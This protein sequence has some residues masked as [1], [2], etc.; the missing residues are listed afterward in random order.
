MWIP[1]TEADILARLEAGDLEETATFDAKEEVS[2]SSKEL[3]K[4]VV[5]MSVEGGVLLYGVGEDDD[6]RV[7]VPAPFVLTGVAERITQ[8][9]GTCTHEPVPVEVKVIRCEEDA[10][11]GYVAVVVSPSPR[12]P[13]MVI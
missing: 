4:D 1:A 13:H 9:I 3:A 6:G 7:T 2:S 8:I 11:Q 5:A 12:A 10:A